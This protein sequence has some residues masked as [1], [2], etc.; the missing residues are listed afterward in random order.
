[1]EFQVEDAARLFL[2]KPLEQTEPWVKV[3]NSNPCIP[4]NKRMQHESDKK[5]QVNVHIR[6]PEEVIES[7]RKGK[8]DFESIGRQLIEIYCKKPMEWSRLLLESKKSTI[9]GF[10][11][12]YATKSIVKQITSDSILE[13]MSGCENYKKLLLL[14]DRLIKIGID[15][16]NPD[17]MMKFMESKELLDSPFIDIYSALWAVVAEY[18]R[19]QGRDIKSSDLYDVPILAMALPFCDIIATDKFI[20]EVSNNLLHFNDTYKAEIYSASKEDL[21][22]LQKRITAC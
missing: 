7:D 3:F 11:G 5:Y 10:M 18:R 15:N 19:V 16:E 4:A 14:I 22:A 17:M 9:D 8:E 21:T 20:K 2:G 12:V 1:M 13:Q 6:L